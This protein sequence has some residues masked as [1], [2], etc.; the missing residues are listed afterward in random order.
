LYQDCVEDEM[1]ALEAIHTRHSVAKVKRDDLPRELIVKLLE[2]GNQAPNHYSVRPWRFVVV[3]GDARKRMGEVMAMSQ[4]ERFPELPPEGSD[5]T[6]ALPLRAPV[7]IAIGVDKPR[8][9]KVI[10]MEN[11]SAASA[12][13]QNILLAAHALGLGAMLRTGE[14]ARDPK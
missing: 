2:A 5:K 10:E 12:A 13:A 7:L 6:R 3:G 1:D 4:R 8:E 11:V 14:W 9:S